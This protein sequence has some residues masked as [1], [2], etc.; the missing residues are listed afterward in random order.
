MTKIRY[1]STSTIQP[2]ASPNKST[3]RIELIPWDLQMLL[4]DFSQ[5]GLFFLIPT[6]SQEKE[7]KGGSVIDHLKTSLSR[8]LEIFYPLVGVGAMVFS[9]GKGEYASA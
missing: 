6:P 2:T 4:D 3:Q 7:L 1:I 5:M 9:L 8:T